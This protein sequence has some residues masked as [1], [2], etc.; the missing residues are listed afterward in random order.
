MIEV[1]AVKKEDMYLIT[2]PCDSNGYVWSTQQLDERSVKVTL[3]MAVK[4]MDEDEICDKI[5][6]I[7][8]D[9]VEKL[10]MREV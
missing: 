2:V 8:K 10:I 5:V 6:R 4:R 1:K 9:V 7:N 3:T